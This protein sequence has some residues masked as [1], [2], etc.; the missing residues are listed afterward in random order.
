MQADGKPHNEHF[1][2]HISTLLARRINENVVLRKTSAA[3]VWLLSTELP[4]LSHVQNLGIFGSNLKHL[5]V[6]TKMLVIDVLK[7]EDKQR[8]DAH[9]LRRSAHLYSLFLREW[10]LRAQPRAITSRRLHTRLPI[11]TTVITFLGTAARQSLSSL[12]S[13]QSSWPS[14]RH[15]SKMHRF[16]PQWKFPGWQS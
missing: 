8:H 12:P 11:R 16:V 5:Q 2:T 13:K 6:P 3:G 7:A 4:R 15:V 9:G 14:Q 1:E 10:S